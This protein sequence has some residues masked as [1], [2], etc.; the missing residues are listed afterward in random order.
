MALSAFRLRGYSCS[1]FQLPLAWTFTHEEIFREP[2]KYCASRSQGCRRVLQRKFFYVFTCEYC[3]SHY[4]TIAILFLTRY[5]L[6]FQ[7]WRG[8]V[9]AGFSLVWIGNLY[10]G[11]FGRLRQEIKSERVEV[12]LELEDLSIDIENAGAIS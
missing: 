9:V 8:Y 1:L 5:H 6:L 7:D 12:A 4:A 2:R 10:I 11:I 3:F